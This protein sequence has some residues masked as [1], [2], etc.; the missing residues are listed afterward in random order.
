MKNSVKSYLSAFVGAATLA[1]VSVSGAQAQSATN[2]NT[3][4]AIGNSNA[5]SIMSAINAR[6]AGQTHRINRRKQLRLNSISSLS[7]NDCNVTINADVT[8]IR[9]IRRNA[10]GNMRM[11]A[12][13]N[14]FDPTR[15]QI[16]LSGSRVDSL[17]LSRTLRLGEA[18]YR[19]IANR[20]LP[21]TQCFSLRR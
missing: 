9:K 16:C 14:S 2:C 11:T 5:T 1:V 7:F 17:R 8:L 3:I 12:R 6:S 13:V 21:G 20:A 10:R 4:E 19:W 15:N 18:V